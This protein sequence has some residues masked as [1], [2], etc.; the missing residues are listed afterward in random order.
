MKKFNSNHA[1]ALAFSAS[2]L[3]F[4]VAGPVAAQDEQ[5]EGEEEEEVVDVTE[6]DTSTSDGA[7]I[8]VTGSRIV[9]DTYTSISP[10]Q[11]LTT[12][13]SQE[14]GLFDPSQI[15]QRSESASGTQIDA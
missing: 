14:A 4:V 13:D 7:P 3:A 9:R 5:P 10:L 11:V 2:A 8:V 6:D 1:K 12:S 15:L